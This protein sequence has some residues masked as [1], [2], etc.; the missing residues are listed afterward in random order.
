[1]FSRLCAPAARAA[2][3]AACLAIPLAAGPARSAQVAAPAAPDDLAVAVMTFGPGD[4]PFFRFGHDAIWIRDRA[5]GTD[6][7]YNFGTFT[8]D[9]PR[10]ILDFLHG[11]MTYWLSVSSLVATQEIYERENRSIVVQ[12]L[13]LPPEVKRALRA[14]LDENARP[15]K[16]A[17]KYD[18]FRDNCATRVRD[19]IDAAV[20]GRLHASALGPGRLTLRGQALRMTAGYLPL[21]VALDLILG[22]DVDLPIDRWAETFIPEE[23]SHALAEVTVPGP[24]GSA[25]L[26]AQTAEVFHPRRAPPLADPPGWGGRFFAWG[27]GVGLCFCAL[28]WWSARPGLWRV[29]AR[30]AF[31]LLVA[32][33]GLGA[34]FVGSFLVYVWVGTDHVVAHRNQNILICAPFA[35]ALLVLGFGVA[36]GRPGATRKA[37]AVASAAAAAAVL[38]CL[39]KI[40]L[41]RHQENG[42]LIAF[43]LPVWMGMTA[44]LGRLRSRA[45][46]LRAS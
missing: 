40:G 22:P 2:A 43:F 46:A 12:V 21:Y 15:D 16:R 8:F 33:F 36:L 37:F 42:A 10:L 4:H 14:K 9:S 20:G 44:G 35:L 3:L 30:A 31:G 13:A 25:P 32:A 29:V 19:A 28:G 17:Y 39:V 23:L 34:G 26:V 18:Y 7:V 24:D 5:A 6:R 41:L 27:L 11:R 45:G 1:M 38:A